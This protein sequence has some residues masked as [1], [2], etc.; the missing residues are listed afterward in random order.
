MFDEPV[1]EESEIHKNGIF[2]TRHIL[3]KGSA[4]KLGYHYCDY[5]PSKGAKYEKKYFDNILRDAT[6]SAP[7]HKDISLPGLHII[8]QTNNLFDPKNAD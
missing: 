8:E 2:G 7:D 3:E 5:W 6:I 4:L 1:L